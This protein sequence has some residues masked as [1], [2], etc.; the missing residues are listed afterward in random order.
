M[1]IYILDNYDSFTYNLYQFIGEIL[2]SERHAG[3]LKDFTLTVKRNDEVTLKD[4]REANPDKIIISPGPGSCEDPAY[5]GVCHEVIVS[6]GEET[7]IL[8]I[9]LGMQGIVHAFGGSIIK[10]PVPMH[11][12]I[13]PIF[14]TGEGIFNG[15]P[16]RLAVMR[17][18]S[19]IA[20][21]ANFPG[22][23]TVTA[24]V[25]NISPEAFAAGTTTGNFEIMAIEHKTWPLYG[26][27]FHPES[28]ATEGGKELI[29]RFLLVDKYD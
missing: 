14:H 7:P 9:C 5:F 22:E 23:L 11:G 1:H 19:L 27:Q 28:Y 17:Y 15:I 16:D 24:T 2:S 4:I 25:G 18:H 13:S 3:R 6:M 21:P 8:G 10:A 26:I 29:S 12:K 20:S